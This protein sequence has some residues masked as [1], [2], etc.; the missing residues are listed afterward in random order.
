[1]TNAGLARFIGQFDRM[2]AAPDG[3]LLERFLAA[4]DQEAFA[5]LVRRHGG[6][7]YGVCSRVLRHRQDAEDAFQATFLILARKASSVR[8]RASLGGWLYRV[9][10]RTA[11]AARASVARRRQQEMQAPD[12]PHPAVGPED[13]RPLLDEAL[14]RLPE[15]YRE[16][17]VLCDLEGHSRTD[18]A[19][20]L[21][22]PEGTLSSRLTAARRL[23]ARRL[24]VPGLVPACGKAALA[25]PACLAETT[26]KAAA[27]AVAGKLAADVPGAALTREVL[28]AMFLTRL[29]AAV[30]VAAVV[31]TLG[32]TGVACRL[33]RTPAVNAAPSTNTD[34]TVREAPKTNAPPSEP[35]ALRREN[36]LL[37]L[38]L[39]IT[40][41]KL[42]A[43]EAEL[44][45]LKGKAAPAQA[46]TRAKLVGVWQSVGSR[47]PVMSVE[48][49]EGG[50]VIVSAEGK[51]AEGERSYVVDGDHMR[52]TTRFDGQERTATATILKLTD[53]ELIFRDEKGMEET[54]K[55]RK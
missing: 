30:A 41:E 21:A 2:T 42:E 26:S 20:L 3:P 51:T 49:T 50:K 55:R 46:R 5:A 7:V 24:S 22:V 12:L 28:K 8:Q 35:E 11:L 15:K 39:R 37:K 54:Y 1:M 52:L 48:F 4:R 16:A 29:K 40:L 10:Y 36:E 43:T 32:V 23:L 44:R 31:V 14:S 47:M 6:M 45:A 33:P 19:R 38:N 18:V 53:E 9:A 27:L 17:L 25:V 13:W 34:A